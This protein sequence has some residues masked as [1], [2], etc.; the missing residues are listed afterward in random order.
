MRK[1]IAY[2]SILI[3]VLLTPLAA[4]AQ[5][6]Y[7]NR[8][9]RI[10][11]TVTPG[12]LVDIFSRLMAEQLQAKL[13]QTFVVENR[14]GSGGII[15]AKSVLQSKPDGYTLLSMTV[16]I[17]P[18]AAMT[19]P[20][21]FGIEDLSPVALFV[22]GGSMLGVR[23]DI[24]VNSIP[25]LIAYAKANPGKLN[26]GSSGIGGPVHLGILQFLDLA[27]IE[28]THIPYKGAIPAAQA[29]L[30]GEVDFGIVDG[31]SFA[32]QIKEGLLRP[33]A[34]TSNISAKGYEDIPPL[35]K[36]VPG[37]NAPFWMGLAGPAGMPEEIRQTLNRAVTEIIGSGVIN[38]R[39]EQ[40][41]LLAKN[42][43]LDELT[44]YV[45]EDASRWERIIKKNN[46]KAE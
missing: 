17:H 7:P 35:S 44:R 46:I 33:L 45:T 18:A 14:P 42:M 5:H 16:G 15:A 36:F 29:M 6:T 11:V 26:Y 1:I 27:G 34:Q 3:F 10:L 39:A 40:T 41:G 21:P 38:A 37:Y 8:P 12:G 28:M 25:E 30:Q 19:D 24:P 32:K 43:P 22:E 2:A 4:V 31:L 23:K 9:V 20:R 13:G